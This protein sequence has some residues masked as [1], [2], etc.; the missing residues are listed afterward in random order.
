M[1]KKKYTKTKYPY[2]YKNIDNNT[3][4]V[5]IDKTI[6][7]KR[8]RTSKSGIKGI[9]EAKNIFK[10]ADEIAKEIYDKKYKK[11]TMLEKRQ[12]EQNKITFELYLES[13]YKHVE[14]EINNKNTIY[15]KKNKFNNYILPFFKEQ[16]N[17][18]GEELD[19]REID[20]MIIERFKQY[21]NERKKKNGEPLSLNTKNTVYSQLSAYFNYLKDCVEIL[22]KNPCAKTKNYKIPPSKIVYYNLDQVNKLLYTIDNDNTEDKKVK[23]LCK[24]VVKTLFFTGYR[25][26]ELFGLKFIYFDYDLINN[27]DITVDYIKIAFK[28]TL[29]Y[30]K[31]GWMES[32]GKTDESLNSIYIGKNALSALFEFVKYMQDN[33]IEYEPNDYIFVNPDTGKVFSVEFIRQKIN[34]YMKIA[35][36]PHLQLKD[37]RHSTATLL[38]SSGYSLEVVKEKLRHSSIRT[39]EKYYATFYEECKIDVAKDI[40]KFAT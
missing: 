24:A 36:L 7:G 32:D 13:Y 25:P 37:F 5:E 14:L 39:T 30:S 19:I 28:N 40:D 34:Y 22:E 3:Y 6:N 35:E 26:S 8:I 12:K 15:K 11:E 10:N 2:I 31:G 16:Q 29:V 1:D 18:Y 33:F 17:D 4:L 23:L 9:T 38:L 27:T 20:F 21:L